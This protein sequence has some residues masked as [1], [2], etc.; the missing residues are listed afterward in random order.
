M[1]KIVRVGDFKD[2]TLVENSCLRD[3]ELDIPER[4]LLLT[5]LSLPDSWDFSGIGL[6]SIL[7]CGKSKVFNSLKKLENAGYL[8]R[9]RVYENGRVADWEYHICGKAI[10]KGENTS[11][12]KSENKNNS[13][14]KVVDKNVDNSQQDTDFLLPE[15]LLSENQEVVSQQVENR[16]DNKIYNNQI[17]ILV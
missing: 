1:P 13:D 9:K 10:F 11:G 17:L 4:G 14:K 12:E 6:T 15:K 3:K 16:Y 5:M 8:K 2:Y 7:P